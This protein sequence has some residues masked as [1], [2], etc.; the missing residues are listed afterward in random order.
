VAEE[1]KDGC[2]KNA[3]VLPKQAQHTAT[4]TATAEWR[5]GMMMRGAR[6]K[7]LCCTA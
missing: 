7:D 5:R 3:L 6:W 4:N 1:V 2:K